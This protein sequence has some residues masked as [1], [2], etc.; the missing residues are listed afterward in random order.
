MMSI[1]NNSR[2]PRCV[3]NRMGLCES[4]VVSVSSTK[5]KLHQESEGRVEICVNGR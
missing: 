3:R 4:E 1:V 5:F 2:Q